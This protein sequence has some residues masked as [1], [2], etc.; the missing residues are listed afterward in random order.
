MQRGA[1]KEGRRGDA[2]GLADDLRHAHARVFER[3]G[4]GEE[5]L[6]FERDEVLHVV[7]RRLADVD[8]VERFEHQVLAVLHHQPLAQR[9]G[10]ELRTHG[11]EFGA[12]GRLDAARNVHLDQRGRFEQTAR[13]DDEV[14]DG[15][16]LGVEIVARQRHGT[17][18]RNDVLLA[19]ID[20]GR[21]V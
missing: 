8:L 3:I 19:H 4:A 7:C 14:L 9:D 5:H 2:A 1:L 15:H 20:L 6:A 18:H 11:R 10:E 13:L 21:D 16:A 17:R 12:H